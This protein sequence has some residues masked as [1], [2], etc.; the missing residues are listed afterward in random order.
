MKAKPFVKW[1][2]GKTQLIEQLEALLP[3]DFDQWENVIYIEPFVG[4]GAMLFYMLQTH[5][6]IKS[7]IINDINPDLTTCYKVV[8][9]F[10]NE[11]VESLKEIQKEYYSL[12]SEESRKN[13]YLMMRDEFN[14]K[15]LNPI[16]NTTLFFFLNRTC[17]NGLYRVNKAGLFNVPFGRYETPTICDANTIYADSKLLE[18]VEILT[19]DYQ[20]TFSHAEGRTL[21]YFD[22]PYRPLN[23]TSSFN[24][25]TKESFN[26]LAQHRLKEFCDKVEAAGYKFMLS[27]SDCADMFFDDLYLQYVIDRVWASR[28]VNSNPNKRGKLQ[29]ILVH[30][31]QDTKLNVA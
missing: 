11:L 28:S 10:P 31:Y 20:E 4:G 24:D 13:Y 30:N 25:Y 7:A 17:F 9:E 26:D 14:T 15:Q 6:N 19:G 18:K 2:G 21:F 5:P 29:E 22:P 1:V 3:A 23:N 27:N 12:K 16:R 8:K